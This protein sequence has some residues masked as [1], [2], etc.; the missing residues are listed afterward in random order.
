[1]PYF[2]NTWRS[3]KPGHFME[4][5]KATAEALKGT[6]KPGNVSTTISHPRPTERNMGVVG[7]ISG[8]PEIADVEEFFEAVLSD[9]SRF[10]SVEKVNAL[11]DQANVSVSQI[12]N[13]QNTGLD[14]FNPKYLQRLFITPQ[15]DKMRELMAILPDMR[16]QISVKSGIVISRSLS[17]P[18]ASIRVSCFVESLESLK[19][20]NSQLIGSPVQKTVQA[21]VANSTVRGL[22]R[23]FYINRPS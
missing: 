16:Q 7:T 10:A 17:G 22:A 19:E 9:E 5:A 6:G 13:P 2:I 12:L 20:F 15:I 23:I 1:M 11:C 4:V 21:S 8:F 14:D 18:S 3:P